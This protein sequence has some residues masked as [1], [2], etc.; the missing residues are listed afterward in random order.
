MATRQY[1]GARYV[2]KFADPVEWDS[3]RS[4]EP[5][6]IVTYLNNSYTSKIPVPAGV[7]IGDT[8]YWVNTG[9]YNG[10]IASLN[11]TVEQLK[12]T[13]VNVSDFG[14]VGDGITD[15]RNAIENAF[16][17]ANV[18]GATV[19]FE[20]KTYLVSKGSIDVKTSVDFNGATIKVTDTTDT[21]LLFVMASDESY[22]LTINNAEL[23]NSGTTNSALKGKSFDIHSPLLIGKRNGHD[24]NIYHRQCLICDEQ[25]NFS[26]TPYYPVVITGD[27]TVTNVQP[28]NTP[29]I[30]FKNVT[31]NNASG[32]YCKFL[33]C[34][35][36]NVIVDG[37]SIVG[38][39]N[40][41]ANGVLVFAGCCYCTIKNVN[42]IDQS[43]SA[44]ASYVL[45]MYS[46]SNFIVENFNTTANSSGEWGAIGSGYISNTSLRNCSTG[47]FDSH[48]ELMGN[49]SIENCT[50]RTG[51]NFGVGWG[52]INVV[53]SYIDGVHFRHD[54]GG[55][56]S[57]LIKIDN[58]VIT[59]THPSVFNANISAPDSIVNLNY[60]GTN[61]LVDNVMTNN[62]VLR[63][64]RLSDSENVLP[65]NSVNMRVSNTNFTWDTEAITVAGKCAN[66]VCFI[67][68]NITSN[69]G[70]WLVRGDMKVF[71][72]IR[73]EFNNAFTGDANCTACCLFIGNKMATPWRTWTNYSSLT[74]VDNIFT[75]DSG[76][77]GALPGTRCF[78][79]NLIIAS[80]KV[81]QPAWNG[82][83]N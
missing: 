3:I 13:V 40:N 52:T 73:C 83:L 19:H 77:P 62:P 16:S 72:V 4:Y 41:V 65:E 78:N 24:E 68:C 30:E 1:I 9:N 61:V 75:N 47:R 12:K 18:T 31:F 71:E 70:G 10:Q 27:Y 38:K 6:I 39:T 82:V 11:E 23:T 28:V 2:P 56:F 17:V 14:A 37:V 22:S 15:D 63:I 57:G 54:T 32:K 21:E 51:V 25:G 58:C 42:A 33:S 76:V 8:K 59:G 80:T 55:F 48:F 7:D 44:T 81:N 53:N 66:K 5:L 46:T 49:N 74:I 50:L 26:N 36:N 43:N 60:T 64:L 20:K 67:E 34:S 35:R 29:V 69:S 45:S 79:N